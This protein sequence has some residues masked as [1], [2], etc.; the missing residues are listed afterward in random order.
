MIAEISNTAFDSFF[1]WAPWVIGLAIYFV[2]WL[3]KRHEVA[4]IPAAPAQATYACSSCGRRGTLE[5]MVPQHHGGAVGYRCP[6]CASASQA[7]A[8]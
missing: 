8:G 3:A 6:Q 5:Q 2:F 7:S 4:T 1:A